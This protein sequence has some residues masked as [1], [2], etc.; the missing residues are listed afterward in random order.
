MDEPEAREWTQ[1]LE[2][3]PNGTVEGSAGWPT[4]SADTATEAEVDL[5]GLDSWQ[6][7]GQTFASSANDVLSH[8]FANDDAAEVYDPSFG[9]DLSA[10]ATINEEVMHATSSNGTGS[11]RPS[12]Q[13]T[14]QQ[15]LHDAMTKVHGPDRPQAENTTP[16]TCPFAKITSDDALVALI[17]SYPRLM[18]RPGIYP[19]FVHHLLYPCETGEVAEP[20]AKAFCCVGAFYASLPTSRSFVCAMMSEESD[21]LVKSFVSRHHH[22]T[23]HGSLTPPE[24]ESL[25]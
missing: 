25:V 10:S 19:P 22:D 11:P 4:H 24:P 8:T 12:K 20:L 9:L 23:W 6:H 15:T 2:S 16:S 14:E 17:R 18:V 21:K 3:E 7:I 13:P 5:F 1:T